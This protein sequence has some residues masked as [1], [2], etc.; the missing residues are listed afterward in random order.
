MVTLVESWLD[1]VGSRLTVTPGGTAPLQ[2]NVRAPSLADDCTVKPMEAV[3][4]GLSCK[5]A[6]S[7]L[8]SRG[9]KSLPPVPVPVPDNDTAVVPSLLVKINVAVRL[10]LTRGVKVTLMLHELPGDNEAGQKLC[11]AKSAGL[12]PPM[13]TL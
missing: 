9:A 7:A 11:A 8:I 13:L 6:E 4:P 1:D 12:A 3:P 10:P 5:V 2:L